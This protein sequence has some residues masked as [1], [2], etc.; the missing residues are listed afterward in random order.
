MKNVLEDLDVEV[1]GNIRIGDQEEG[2]QK[3]D[4]K[5]VVKRSRFKGG[6]DFVLGDG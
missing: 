3:Y 1:E 6:G 2:D 4:M 5:N